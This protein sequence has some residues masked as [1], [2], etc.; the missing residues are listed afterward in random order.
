[1]REVRRNLAVV[2]VAL[3]VGSTLPGA[4]TAGSYVPPPGDA[5]PVWSPDGTRIAFATSRAGHALAALASVGGGE[6][7]LLEGVAA[8]D[9]AISPDWRWIAFTRFGR[10]DDG[11]RIIGLDGTGERQVAAW[12]SQP[13]WSPDSRSI[14]FRAADGSLSVVEIDGSA[15]TRI[16][17]LGGSWAWSPD[18]TRIAFGGGGSGDQE[19]DVYLADASGANL[20]LLTGGPGADLEPKWSP[21]GTRIAFLTQKEVG[22][23]FRFG[24]IQPDG[25]GLVTY[26]GPRVSN[27][28]S[29]AWLPGS[30]G[31]VF[32]RDFSQG[33]FLLDLRSGSTTRLTAFGATPSPSPDGQNV[34]F[35]AGGECRDRY[36]IYVA[37]SDG[38]GMRRL[39]NDCRVLGTPATMSFAAPGSPM[40]FSGC[41]ATIAS[42][43]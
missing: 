36:G 9:A 19:P 23:P 15:T 32:A 28:L 8:Y 22:K 41:G 14:A 31:I 39:T 11:L 37:R 17:A 29:F 35:A 10:P 38:T 2:V 20:R 5:L 4:S 6:T 34:A 1:M 12:G 21:D 3:L 18:G 33:L 25:T 43:A 42:R 26:P 24:L 16:A 30:D 7:R 13:V 40:C 27:S